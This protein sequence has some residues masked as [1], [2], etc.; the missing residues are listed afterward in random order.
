MKRHEQLYSPRGSWSGNFTKRQSCRFIL[1]K[2]RWNNLF[3]FYHHV[4]FNIIGSERRKR[5]FPCKRSLFVMLVKLNLIWFAEY[6]CVHFGKPIMYACKHFREVKVKG[7]LQI[8]SVGNS[9][10]MEQEADNG[11]TWFCSGSV[12]FSFMI[13]MHVKVSSNEKTFFVHCG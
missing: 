10:E 13:C 11:R 2:N 7:S 4:H 8:F 5:A 6:V 1:Q 3:V 12:P 9:S